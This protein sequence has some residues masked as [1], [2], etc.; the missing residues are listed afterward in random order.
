MH[1]SCQIY[2][3]SEVI[4]IGYLT[5]LNWIYSFFDDFNFAVS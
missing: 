5:T 1:F 3:F 4:V 2:S